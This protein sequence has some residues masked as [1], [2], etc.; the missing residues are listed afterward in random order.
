MKRLYFI[1]LL[2][3]ILTLP[4]CESQTDRINKL[5]PQLADADPLIESQAYDLLWA[6]G[7]PAIGPL[8]NTLKGNSVV[9]V[10]CGSAWLLGQTGE[11]RMIAP[12]ISALKDP[13]VDVGQYAAGALLYM[14]TPAVGPLIIALQGK[15]IQIRIASAGVLG[16][17]GDSSAVDPLINALQDGDTSLRQM[18]AIA[19]ANMKDARAVKPLIAALRNNDEGVRS[20]AMEALVDIGAPA[21][22]PLI[23]AL[24]D[25]VTYVVLEDATQLYVR[26]EA[27]LALGRIGDIRAV[28]PLID[29]L[30]DDDLYF[31]RDAAFA[32]SLMGKSALDPLISQLNNI[33]SGVVRESAWALG[34]IKDP[35]AVEP[36][37]SVIQ[38]G[39]TPMR[40]QAAF[41][42]LN[43][44]GDAAL[45]RLQAFLLDALQAQDLKTI[46]ACYD[47]YIK[48]GDP[49]T[50]PALIAALDLYADAYGNYD[51]NGM[52]A[53]AERFLNCGNDH[54]HSAA[55]SWGEGHSFNVAVTPA[56]KVSQTWGPAV[57]DSYGGQAMVTWGNKPFNPKE[58]Y[59]LYR[60]SPDLALVPSQKGDSSGT[61]G[62]SQPSGSGSKKII[63]I[64]AGGGP[65]NPP[66]YRGRQP[67]N[68]PNI[69]WKADTLTDSKRLTTLPA[70]YT[71][72]SV[73]WKIT[74][75]NKDMKKLPPIKI[76]TIVD[77]KQIDERY[78]GGLRP[79]LI[80]WSPRRA[81]KVDE[82]RLH[83]VNFELYYEGKQCDSQGWQFPVVRP[84]LQSSM[85]FKILNFPEIQFP[86]IQFP[87][88]F[89]WMQWP[90][91]P[92]RAI[93]RP[94]PVQGWSRTN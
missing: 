62:K 29:A 13:A 84:P 91:P 6:E 34:Q 27:A 11:S 43:A 72:D 90:K 69:S 53:I 36:L 56:A 65:R 49:N 77:G 73:Q 38:H 68:C 45:P 92:G 51:D 78:T 82:A 18:A 21:V 41:E 44:M 10:R 8:I 30:A 22:E 60:E 83:T 2:A 35:H 59:V 58:V 71:G 16:Q 1:G 48:R 64:Y 75:Q 47:F 52:V 23:S 67:P 66:G 87:N 81:W 88:I 85:K 39:D 19:L 93:F 76:K 15:D 33:D 5:I 7:E 55:I 40:G 50:E 79:E 63:T 80:S 14:G 57:Y 61:S 86:D 9:K 25:D 31:R 4:A 26:Q 89:P 37:I 54:L 28:Q 42:A 46:A 12:L 24:Y 20:A 3:A 94:M 70:V 32:L 74:I 17:I